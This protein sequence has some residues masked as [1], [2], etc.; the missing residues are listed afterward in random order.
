MDHSLSFDSFLAGAR[1]FTDLAMAARA[2][3]DHELFAL[4]A[5]VAIERL[6]KANLARRAP[7]LLLEMRSG[8]EMLFHLTGV[9]DARKV[10]T[11]GI[12]E[13]ITRLRQLD[14]LPSVDTN[15]D[16]LIA[17]RNGVAHSNVAESTDDLLPAFARTVDTLLESVGENKDKF[18]GRWRETVMLATSGAASQVERDVHMRIE[19]AKYLFR[20]PHLTAH[21]QGRRE[22]SFFGRG[23]RIQLRNDRL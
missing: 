9:K 22:I 1:K 12:A 6:A 3:P 4:Q 16:L 2:M 18:W 11:I 8:V 14:V 20:H 15:L 7:V 17:L 21:R 13:A 23:Q 10:R 5:G 19:N